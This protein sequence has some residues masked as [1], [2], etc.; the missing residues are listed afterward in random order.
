[1][2]PQENQ[3]AQNSMA[4]NLIRALSIKMQ[5]QISSQSGIVPA[6]QPSVTILPQMVGL[7]KGFWVQVIHT[8]DNDSGVQIDLTDFGPANALAQI[9]FQDLQNNTRIQ[10]SGWHLAFINSVKARRPFGSSLVRSTGFD[11]PINYGDIFSGGIAADATIAASASGTVTMWYWVP[12]AYS[13]ED[14]RGSIY[15][16]V[17]QATMRMILSLPG[18]YGTAVAVANGA[19]STLAMYV[20][21]SAGSVADVAISNTQINVWQVY[22]DQIPT[23]PKTK[24]PI[25][26]LLDLATVYELKQTTINGATANQNFPYQY[27][28]YRQF[29]STFGVYINTGA[30]GARGTGSDINNWALQ[31]A[32][33]TNIWQLPPSLISL[34]NRNFMGVDQPPGVY[35]FSTREKPISTTQYGNMQLVL[36]PATAAAGNYL[37]VAVEDFALQ[38]VLSMAGSLPAAQ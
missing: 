12:L 19:D 27:A 35:Y 17:V 37:M 10:T 13:D 24:A 22:Q 2:T 33:F 11:S 15:A 14:L 4:R 29:L 21:H 20:G 1:M 34:M 26:P 6:L 5:Q 16:N 23:D 32:N 3:A 36:N 28:N 30:T 7:V 25:L 8:I 18:T 9:Q 38:T 31:A